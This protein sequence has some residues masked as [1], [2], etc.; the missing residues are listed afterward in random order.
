MTMGNASFN[1]RALLRGS[2][3][4][5]LV[6]GGV[7]LVA[8]IVVGTAMMVGVFRERAL[9]SAEREL[10]NTVL[11]LARHFDQ[12]LNDF[13]TIQREA[14]AQ[15]QLEKLATPEAFR[16]QMSTRDLH[17]ALKAKASGHNDVAGV[18]V[19]DANGRLINSSESWPVPGVD[20][21]DRAY[22][23]TFKSGTVSPTILIELLRSRFSDDWATV[24][25]YQ[26]TAPNGAFLG[27]ITRAITPASFEKFF[28]SLT[29][30]EGGAISMYHRDGT[31]LARYPH[32]EEMIGSNFT[33]GPV[34]RQVLSK[35][36]HGTI[37][38]TSPIDGIDRLASARALSEFP[39][40]VIATTTVSAAL[41][42]W[43]EQTRFLIAIA[44]VSVLLIAGMLFLV[45][46]KL[47]RQHRL[48]KQR[49]D[50]AV[51]NI[52][53]GLVVYDSSAHVT[54]CNR[55]YIEMFGLSAD[56]A[57]PGCAMR[58]LIFHRKETGSFDGDV[59][60]FCSS[61]VR[62]MSLGRATN[63]ITEAPGGRAIQIINQPLEAGGWVATIEDVTERREAEARI[64]HL[65][66][67]DPLTDLPNRALFHQ[68]L[69]L[70]LTRIAAGEQL[71]VLYIDI[72]EFK[73]VN[74]TLGHL[75]GDELLKSVASSLSGCIQGDD[76]VARLGGDEFAV[77]ATA[78]KS[79]ADIIGLATRIFDAIRMPYECLGHQVTTDASI[80]VALAPQHGTDLS[81]ILK[82][83]DMA[84]YAAKSAGRRTYRFFE[85]DMDAQVKARRLLEMDLRQAMSQG[86][87]E[88]YYQP[89]VDLQDNKITGCE[90]LLRW[91]HPERG[92]VSPAEFIPIAE[93]TGLINQIGE[94]VLTTACAEAT[95]W[96]ADI[97]IAVNVSPIQFKSGTL[98]LK[99]V[100]A[101]A[102]SGLAA[103][104]LELEITEAVLIRDD[105]AALA[106]LHQLRAIGVRIALDDF[107]TG[108][109]SLSYLQRFPF[110]KIKID[111]CFVSD[112]ADSDASSSIVRAVVSIA[113]AR[114]ITTTAEGV[115]TEE[116]RSLLRTFGCTEMQGFLFSPAKPAAEL[117][118][119][120]F[121]HRAKRKALV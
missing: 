110:D 70:E 118:I 117:E 112:I 1:I 94:W 54:V 65:A 73:S 23:K 27:V 11:L 55:R 42:D 115:E 106:I 44:A 21:S 69:A 109:S 35:A 74:D 17:Q 95:T 63:Q 97:K 78:V 29:L 82:N 43:R 64:T 10:D 59:E 3:V 13:I 68:R 80:G 14:A 86:A 26:V 53:Q 83:A 111:R 34:H 40:S 120:F 103:S 102:A 72:D 51:N 58:D 48:E 7:L 9:Q 67:Y 49:L 50:T 12:Q 60:E 24:I 2:P 47:S 85:P 25:A 30:G 4:R 33:S 101:L 46:R 56:V 52:P 119:L 76:F 19:F 6:L 31:L 36:D 37:R 121:S 79:E 5:G 45:V 88:V 93:E 57:K 28:A 113:A 84:M 62:D 89:C 20:I 98:A 41:A 108:Y 71:A 91:R 99:I 38:L 107:G 87:L 100:A 8:G 61:I 18:N 81:Q 77:V 92:M 66:H 22:F 96:P 16:A 90:A 15:A 105:D 75:I 104:R 114:N 39:I 32:V 116:Q